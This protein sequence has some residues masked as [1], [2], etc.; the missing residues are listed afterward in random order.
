M[1]YGANRHHRQSESEGDDPMAQSISERQDA[2]CPWWT[3]S[4]GRRPNTTPLND[5]PALNPAV[6]D[7]NIGIK[8][9]EQL[10]MLNQCKY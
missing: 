8:H 2:G 7:R 5:C 3:P 9:D 4:R 10:K 1:L 6:L